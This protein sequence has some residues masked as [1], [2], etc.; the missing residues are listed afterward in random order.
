MTFLNDTNALPFVRYVKRDAEHGAVDVIRVPG[1]VILE[2]A[3]EGPFLD[4]LQNYSNGVA[5]GL[6]PNRESVLNLIDNQE[7]RFLAS[8]AM[9]YIDSRKH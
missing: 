2:G 9:D 7:L 3:L 6:R 5:R 4:A 8:G 1:A